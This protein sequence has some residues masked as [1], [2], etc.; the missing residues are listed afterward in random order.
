MLGNTEE[1]YGGVGEDR[2]ENGTLVNN[3]HTAVSCLHSM[4]IFTKNYINL[5]ISPDY[6]IH[7]YTKS[8]LATR[9]C[10]HPSWRCWCP[11][12]RTSWRRLPGTATTLPLGCKW[13]QG[14]RAHCRWRKVSLSYIFLSKNQ[15]DLHYFFIRSGGDSGQKMSNLVG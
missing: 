15:S 12:R 4:R 10:C 8:V 9:C 14:I 2:L 5:E 3:G 6:P 13:H 11:Q 7:I 1:N